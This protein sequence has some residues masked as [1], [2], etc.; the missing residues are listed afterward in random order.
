[1]ENNIYYY[2]YKNMNHLATLALLEKFTDFL[3]KSLRELCLLWHV[4]DCSIG[5]A[6][7]VI[8]MVRMVSSDK[9]MDAKYAYVEQLA[10]CNVAYT[11]P[12]VSPKICKIYICWEFY[13][14]ESPQI[15]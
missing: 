9:K 7:R 13:K 4:G 2:Y 15:E 3:F 11:Q 8:V 14:L 12:N 5:S 10:E 1:M 6:W